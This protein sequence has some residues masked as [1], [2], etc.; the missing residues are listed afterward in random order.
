MAHHFT[1]IDILEDPSKRLFTSRNSIG[2]ASPLALGGSP[3]ISAPAPAATAA[4]AAS[5]AHE[6]RTEMSD[7]LEARH[8]VLG[9]STAFS[10]KSISMGGVSKTQSIDV[11]SRAAESSKEMAKQINIQLEVKVSEKSHDGMR[12]LAA[13]TASVKTT[14]IFDELHHPLSSS[15]ISF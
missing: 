10:A 4:A 1:E 6:S 11:N 13:I 15:L 8:I 3:L 12:T 7:E 9:K 2:D 14:V 5:A